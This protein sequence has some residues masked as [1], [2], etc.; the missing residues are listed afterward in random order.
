[1][2]L[3]Q[4]PGAARGDAHLFV[5]VTGRAPRRERVAEPEPAFRGD[6]V[7]KIGEGRGALIG[8]DDEIG[9]VAVVA[10]DIGRRHDG[11]PSTIVRGLGNDI[12]RNVEQTA[13]QHLIALDA[14]GGELIARGGWSLYDKATLRT[15]R[16]DDRVL[17]GLRLHQAEDLGPEILLA[18][19]PSD[20]AAR[21]LPGAHVHA[22]DARAVNVDLEQRAW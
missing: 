17:D 9:I 21:D 18:V 1:M 16:H 22:L 11:V 4:F 19:G 2:A 3:D 14:L 8:G 10:H 5:V 20:A 12:I 15:D 13:D 6:L 7:S